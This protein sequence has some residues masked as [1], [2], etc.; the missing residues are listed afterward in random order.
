MI[1]PTSP[2]E[3]LQSIQAVSTTAMVPSLDTHRLLSFQG[4]ENRQLLEFLQRSEDATALIG[5]RIAIVATDGVEEIELTIPLQKFRAMGADVDLVAPESADIESLGIHMPPIRKTH[6][7]TIRFI[8]PSGWHPVDVWLS[9][10]NASNYDAVMIPGGA[11][12]PDLLRG[13]PRVLAFL[14]QMDQQGGL[15]TAICH[16][17]QVL[18]SAGLVSG[19]KATSWPLMLVDLENAGATHVDQP[20]VIDD[21]LVTSRGPLDLPHFVDAVANRLR[22]GE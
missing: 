6:I 18:I 20:V 19:K 15:I 5:K 2:H 13:D 17:P 10:A 21:R 3:L 9:D 7:L 12:N 1:D 8:E 16:G 22:D 14:K 11:W 4:S